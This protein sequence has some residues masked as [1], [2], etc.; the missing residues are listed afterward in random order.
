MRAT[1]GPSYSMWRICVQSR[2]QFRRLSR[3]WWAGSATWGAAFE[4]P[5]YVSGAD[6][7]F[8]LR[9]HGPPTSATVDVESLTLVRIAS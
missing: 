2:R 9:H 1:P 5:V 6:Q 3:R 4:E 7:G 8:V